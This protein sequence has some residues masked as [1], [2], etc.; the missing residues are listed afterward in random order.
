MDSEKHQKK[1]YE[2]IDSKRMVSH[3]NNTKWKHLSDFL[4]KNN[5][6]VLVK[7]IDE[8]RSIGNWNTV[9]TFA[10]NSLQ[11]NPDPL[12]PYYDI[13]W[14]I[15]NGICLNKKGE[16]ISVKNDLSEEIE[17]LFRQKKYKWF[18]EKC[19]FMVIAHEDTAVNYKDELSFYLKNQKE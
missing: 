6:R 10:Q 18:K 11:L 17:K 1:M 7:F 16:L 14:I 19:Y 8:A 12:T 9:T 2:I 4:E 3:L 5:L 15:I 13:E